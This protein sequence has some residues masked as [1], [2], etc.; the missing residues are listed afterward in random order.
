F[1]AG[2][3]RSPALAAD[4]RGRCCARDELHEDLD[5]GHAAEQLAQV[6]RS[7]GR[8]PASAPSSSRVGPLPLRCHCDARLGGSRGRS[9]ALALLRGREANLSFAISESAALSSV[10]VLGLCLCPLP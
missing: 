3:A 7:R 8:E 10:I 6:S 5:R 2:S 9:R 1:G 4:A